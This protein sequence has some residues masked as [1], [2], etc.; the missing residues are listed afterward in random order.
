MKHQKTVTKSTPPHR[1]MLSIAAILIATVLSSTSLHA[2]CQ[3]DSTARTPPG[4]AKLQVVAFGDSL[5]D[6]GTYQQF[7]KAKFDGGEFTTNPSKVYVQDIACTYGDVLLPAFQG[8]FGE[9]LK[10][11][12]GLD[13]AEGGSR[14]ALQP[15]INHA[16]AGTPNAD[17][18]EETTIP[19]TEQLNRYLSEH[20]RF[21]PNQL[22]IIN[23]GANDI[24]FNLAVAEQV[25]TPAALQA[26]EQAI[27]QSA[28][29]LANVVEVVIAKGATHV[30][31]MS[32]PDI[33][34]TP[35]GV[36]SADHGQS[37][38]QISQLFNSTLLGQLK[39]KNQLDKIVVL[40]SF[41]IIDNVVANFQEFGFKVSNT[42]MA[43]N[44]EA[45]IGKATA[46][47]LQNPTFFGESLFCSPATFTTPD[48][49]ESFMFADTVHPSAHLSAIFAKAA[50]LQIESSGLV[51]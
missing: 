7:A 26:A 39:S 44:L 19:V 23:G 28:L 36:S 4:G 49:A 9:P 14:V 47:S 34:T 16:A 15:G 8:G 40:D 41:G 35:Q 22:V 25:G 46:L 38:T 18:S 45:Q 13:Y 31:L 12:G 17:F 27:A 21:H 37:L 10:P 42:G 51:R 2:A 1:A 32:L 33:G 48:A 3:F 6:T 50:E 5:L 24:F 43:C 30:V 20:Q 29:D 11:S